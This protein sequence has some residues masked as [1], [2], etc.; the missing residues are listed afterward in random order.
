MGAVVAG[1]LPCISTP[2][3][4]DHDQR[5]KHL[6]HFN[7]L[8]EQPT[9][10]T[11]AKLIPDF[12]SL[13]HLKLRAIETLDSCEKPENPSFHAANLKQR[14][15]P[16]VLMLTSGSTGYAKAV[17]LR[18]GQ[19][20]AALDRKSRYH[21]TTSN[22]VFLN[23][24]SMDHVANLTEIHLHAMSLGDEQIHVK[25]ADLVMRPMSFLSLIHKH[26][27]TYTFVPNFFLAS[28]RRKLDD[29][30][31]PPPEGK[32]LDLSSLKAL[33]SGG[34]ANVVETC[35]A[36]TKQ[37][38]QYRACGDFIR[39]RFGMT[40]TCAGSIYGK[41]CP[42][43][44]LK[45]EL[46]F[47]SLGSCIPGIDMRIITDD[48]REAIGDETGS[49]QV[50]EYFNNPQAT[51]K[52]F[53]PDGWFTTGDRAMIDTNGYLNLACRTK[54]SIIINGVKH[55]PHEL[56]TALD[57]AGILGITSS[58]NL[59]FAHRP[60]GSE[61][62]SLCVVYLPAYDQQ[63][64]EARANTADAIANVSGMICG[65][66]PHEIIPL[67]ESQ[68]PKS[69]LGKLSRAKIRKAFENGVYN[70]SQSRNNDAI[71]LY[72]T[73]QREKPFNVTEELILAVIC[74][75]FELPTDEIGVGNSLFN[76]GVKSI[77]LIGFK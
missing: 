39:P 31:D 2:F 41:S 54:E 51:A 74:E 15:D 27:V 46:E 20:L 28:L 40:E 11:S 36:L 64:A 26:H 23:W 3:V 42:L 22:D 14:N 25:A 5:N 7:D 30:N 58:Y 24:I 69:S 45:S 38:H 57:E 62:E 17:C 63:D 65:V 47:A 52:A 71:K 12:L 44:D 48:G 21:E 59:V 53:T 18:H 6:I 4:N 43:Y 76:F 13:E 8:L 16:A 70:D 50:S 10:L 66:R 67:E 19:V 75:R 68:L 35:A 72:R 49:L 32:N 60:K 61:T 55:F 37:L 34:E 1:C 56:E 33:I 9:I 73:T 77:D 29:D